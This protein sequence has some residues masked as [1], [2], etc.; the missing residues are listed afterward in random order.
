MHPTLDDF[1]QTVADYLAWEVSSL[2]KNQIDEEVSLG[3][4]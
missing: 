2:I 3:K 4:S 1:R